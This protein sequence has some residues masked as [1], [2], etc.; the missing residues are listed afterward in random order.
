MYKEFYGEPPFHHHHHMGPMEHE[1]IANAAAYARLN[2]KLSVHMNDDSRHITDEEREKWN[3]AADKAITDVDEILAEKADV[4]DIPTK[5]SDLEDDKGFITQTQ[6]GSIID[7]LNERFIPYNQLNSLLVGYAREEQLG[8]YIKNTDILFT[9]GGS[10]VRK[11]DSIT[12]ASGGESIHVD[13]YVLPVATATA[14]GG[15]KVGTSNASLGN[16]KYPVQLTTNQVAYVYVPGSSGSGGEM[17]YEYIPTYSIAVMSSTMHRSG[18]VGQ[19][20]VEG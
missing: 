15:I 17:T 1:H 5:L 4:E 9:Y 16:N 2:T 3:E 18:S 7:G 6:F 8:Q 11:G 12:P 13:P 10:A 20:K 14:L 19:Y